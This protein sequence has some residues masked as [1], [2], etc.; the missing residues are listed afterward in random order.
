ME[1]SV[2][3]QDSLHPECADLSRLAP[4]RGEA[5]L[6]AEAEAV[7]A[8]NKALRDRFVA[9]DADEEAQQQGK[10]VT[11]RRFFVGTAATVTA[12]STA[13][14]ISTQASFAATPTGTL[15]HVFLYG[16]MDG[17][18][19]A[20]PMNDPTLISVRP[21]F[22]LQNDSIPL[23]RG[24]GLTS[25]FAPLRKFL[26]AGQVGFVPGVSDRRIDRSH[27]NAQ[28]ICNL[29]GLPSETGGE[30]WLSGL[31]GK[32]GTGT[33]FRS[34]GIGATLPRSQVG[35]N[36]AVALSSVAS[37]NI[38]GDQQYKQP[39]VDA[40][41]TLFTGID[42]P[43]EQPVRAGLD[44]LTTA[45]SLTK[46]PYV[47]ANGVKY[48]GIGNAFR[49]LALLIKGGANVRIA[50]VGMGGWDTHENQGTHKGGYLYGNLQQLAQGMADFFTDLGPLAANVTV[51][52]TTEF[53]RRVAENGGG[54]DHGKGSV[55]TIVSGKKLAGKLLG[56]WNG[57]GTLTQGDVPEM[58]NLFNLYGSVAQGRFGLSTAEVQS[59]FPRQTYTPIQ[60]FA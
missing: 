49:E 6:R 21:D 11:R 40:I 56:V 54:T 42:H 12:L 1:T 14:F 46:T 43:V 17:L 2:S 29:G 16:G 51:L 5:L 31:A 30:G 45:V 20:A 53:G 10:G 60:V 44:A 39:T 38:N 52:V 9:L 24:F 28:D 8:E 26:D 27:F 41:R 59:I 35:A 58:N 47:P 37:L 3:K 32:L 22:T 57:L 34:V 48:T 23:D 4:T 19:L 7:K 15:I 36:N 25:A 18:S 33:A 55:A 50:T 13:Q